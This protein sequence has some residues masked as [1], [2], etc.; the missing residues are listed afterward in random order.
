[1]TWDGHTEP[2]TRIRAVLDATGAAAFRT[3]EPCDYCDPPANLWTWVHNGATA[4]WLDL[5]GI[6]PWK[7]VR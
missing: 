6:G 7:E 1:M 3:D 4:C 5:D 2:P